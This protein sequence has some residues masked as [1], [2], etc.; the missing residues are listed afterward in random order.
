MKNKHN[1]TIVPYVIIN[2]YYGQPRERRSSQIELIITENRRDN[3]CLENKFL[4]NKKTI[5]EINS[6]NEYFIDEPKFNET[7]FNETKFNENK[8]DLPIYEQLK[9][10]RLKS[11]QLK[12]DQLKSDQ[13]TPKQIEPDQ[14][15]KERFKEIQPIGNQFIGNKFITNQTE[16][17][18]SIGNQS[19][20]NKFITNQAEKKQSEIKKPSKEQS[21]AIID[22]VLM[23][24]G[25][26]VGTF[27]GFYIQME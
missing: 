3:I 19:I 14:R 10:N 2:E 13:L 5:I 18:Q 24:G 16:K 25:A 27:L 9:R 11:D 6:D 4:E 23:L 8:F 20:G 12:S 22:N 15:F 26:V 1:H 21:D 17:N 7:K